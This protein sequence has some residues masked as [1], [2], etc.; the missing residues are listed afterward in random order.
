MAVRLA[1]LQGTELL[2]WMPGQYPAPA[3]ALPF[4][5]QAGKPPTGTLGAAGSDHSAGPDAPPPGSCIAGRVFNSLPFFIGAASQPIW[6]PDANRRRPGLTNGA[7][8]L[9]IKAPVSHR[10]PVTGNRGRGW[11]LSFPCSPWRPTLPPAIPPPWEKSHPACQLSPW[12]GGNC[13]LPPPSK[14]GWPVGHGGLGE[15]TLLVFIISLF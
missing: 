3:G 7:A 5:A 15:G 12:V 8:C 13:P 4:R 6:T 11:G 1:D 14:A 2:S 9:K 10:A